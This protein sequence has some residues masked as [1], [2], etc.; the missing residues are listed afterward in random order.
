MNNS[1]ILSLILIPLAAVAVGFTTNNTETVES[2]VV[3]IDLDQYAKEQLQLARESASLGNI[4]DANH[5]F[6]IC[7]KRSTSEE[8]YLTCIN[9]WT[10]FILGE[11]QSRDNVLAANTLKAHLIHLDELKSVDA[12]NNNFTAEMYYNLSKNIKLTRKLCLENH[13]G[14]MEDARSI[15][16]QA[17]G[18]LSWWPTDWNDNEI[19]IAKALHHANLASIYYDQLDSNRRNKMFRMFQKLWDDL[20]STEFAIQR[21]MDAFL[22]GEVERH[23]D[24]MTGGT[25]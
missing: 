3:A 1:I 24:R 4:E 20:S 13:D 9:D 22:V 16:G 25:R 21:N 2:P 12:A 6:A 17:K 18:E 14:L 8:L 10:Q 15:Y 23:L 11:G 5:H 7:W 19:G